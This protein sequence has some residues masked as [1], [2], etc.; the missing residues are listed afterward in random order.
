MPQ[1]QPQVITYIVN[2]Q[3]EVITEICK[4]YE[5]ADSAMT[6]GSILREALKNESIALIILYD[7]PGTRFNLAHVNG[8][9]PTS[10]EGIFW[11]FFHWIHRGSFEV[12]TDAFTTFRVCL[13]DRL[14]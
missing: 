14:S 12:N 3:P 4:H 1:G 13:S 10:G 11:Q 2:R 9:E 7:E 6:C 8:K 5:H